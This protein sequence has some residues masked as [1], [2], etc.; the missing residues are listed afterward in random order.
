MEEGSVAGGVIRG[1][2]QVE[3]ASRATHEDA[4]AAFP[5]LFD[6][7]EVQNRITRFAGQ[8]IDGATPPVQQSA[9]RVT[10][11]SGHTFAVL[12]VAGRTAFMALSS[13][14]VPNRALQTNT[15]ACNGGHC[16]YDED[17]S[18]VNG[19]LVLATSK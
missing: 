3:F 9:D 7:P 4:A 18:A 12:S 5:M 17:S 2:L 19:P 15:L 6:L 16:T 11:P 14:H 8:Y 13:D 10:A 1:D